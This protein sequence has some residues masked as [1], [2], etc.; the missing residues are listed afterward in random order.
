MTRSAP[1]WT[2]DSRRHESAR[3]KP[4][5]Q[6][7]TDSAWKRPIQH[8]CSSRRSKSQ[9]PGPLLAWWEARPPRR[10]ERMGTRSQTNEEAGQNRLQPLEEARDQARR[11]H[12]QEARFPPRR[13]IRIHPVPRA[14]QGDKRQLLQAAG[15]IRMGLL[16]SPPNYGLL[17][18]QI[19]Q[20]HCR[21]STETSISLRWQLQRRASCSS[22]SG[23][24]AWSVQCR[25]G[26]CR[27]SCFGAIPVVRKT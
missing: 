15:R 23:D 20:P 27:V 14:V 7:E 3:S 19:A 21:G 2:G 9:H 25:L 16:R 5:T 6:Q 10:T 12:R 11:S 1:L 18:D 26:R 8:R 24:L 4:R 17:R 13:H 22:C